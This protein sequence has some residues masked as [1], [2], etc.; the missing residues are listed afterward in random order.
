[1]PRYIPMLSPSH[2]LLITSLKK[3]IS[4]LP[5]FH[6]NHS[7]PPVQEMELKTTD[8]SGTQYFKPLCKLHLPSYSWRTFQTSLMIGGPLM[9]FQN[10]FPKSGSILNGLMF[11]RPTLGPIIKETVCSSLHTNPKDSPNLFFPTPTSSD[12]IRTSKTYGAGNLTLYG[13]VLE[14][15]TPTAMDPF[16]QTT[17]GLHR[18]IWGW[19][20]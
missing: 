7:V 1:M 19:K 15:P 2:Q 14:L 11:E 5:V 18:R 17:G 9:K 20:E 3:W 13:K 10:P 4:S 8:G 16:K 6:V 12:G